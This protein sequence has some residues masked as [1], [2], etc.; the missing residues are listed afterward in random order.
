MDKTK[1][2]YKTIQYKHGLYHIDEVYALIKR[3]TDIMHIHK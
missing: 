1:C 3:C 2:G